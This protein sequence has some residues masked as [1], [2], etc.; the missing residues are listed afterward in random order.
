MTYKHTLQHYA[1]QYSR[2]LSTIKRYAK[3]NAPLDDAEMMQYFLALQKDTGRV[4]AS[5]TVAPADVATGYLQTLRSASGELGEVMYH[6]IAIVQSPDAPDS[7]REAA[8]CQIKPL[9]DFCGQFHDV[10]ES[11]GVNVEHDIL[12]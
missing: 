7:V 3:K 5:R 12:D 9:S 10:F 4:G 8:K 1:D 6:I 11:A 2:S